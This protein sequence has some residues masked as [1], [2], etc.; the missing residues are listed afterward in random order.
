MHGCGSGGILRI[1]HGSE[2]T[3]LFRARRRAASFSRA[4]VV[5]GIA[6]SALSRQVRALEIELR[7]DAAAAQRSWRDADRG[8][9]APA[10]AQPGH[11]AARRRGPRRHGL[12]PRRAGRPHHH[13]PAADHRPPAHAAADRRIPPPH[14]PGPPRDRRGPVD[15]HRRMDHLG[16]G[17]SGPALQPGGPAGAGVR[18]AAGGAAVPGAACR[19]AGPGRVRGRCRWPSWPTRSWCCP[20]APM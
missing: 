8:R 6:Q 13:R 2:T 4:A 15:P 20:S 11:P 1:R 3:G 16:P 10:R 19:C 12:Q 17:R 18:A 14:A 5:L 9:P 7:E